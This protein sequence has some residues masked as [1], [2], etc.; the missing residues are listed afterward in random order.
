MSVDEQLRSVGILQKPRHWKEKYLKNLDKLSKPV[1]E[2]K[3]T[4]NVPVYMRD[5]CLTYVDIYSP[6]TD[7]GERFPGLVAFSAYGK[8][9]Q[10]LDREPLGLRA[11]TF[12]HTIEAGDIEYY[13]RRGYVAAI[14][15]PRGVGNSE[16]VWDGLYGR[17]EAE[18]CYDVI[19]W[20][21]RQEYCTGD[22]GM[23]GISYFSILQPLVAALQPPHLRAIMPVEVVDS[24]YHH[25]YP[26]GAFFDRSSIYND[27]CPVRGYSAS[28][29]MYTEEE[30]KLRIKER[31]ENPDTAQSALLR[32]VLTTW[33]PRHQSYFFDVVLH[34]HDDDFWDERSIRNRVRDI[35]VPMYLISEYYE[36]GR[37]TQGPFFVYN[38]CDQSVPRKVFAPEAHNSIRLPHRSMSEEYLRWYDHWLKGVDTGIMD[39]PPIK[40]YITELDRYRYEYEWPIARTS[41]IKLYLNSGGVLSE[42]GPSPKGAPPETFTHLPPLQNP[43]N[44]SE[45]PG[46]S[47]ET[48]ALE[49]DTEVTGNIALY[50]SAALSAPDGVFGINLIDVDENG[51]ETTVCSGYLRAS[52]RETKNEL[53]RPWQPTHDHTKEVPVTPGEIRSYAIEILP[54]S[55][56]FFAG[57]RI[58]ITVK[59]S[60]PNNYT[61]LT[62]LPAASE[63]KYDLSVDSEHPSYLLL[64]IIETSPEENWID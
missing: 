27:F 15:D 23:V 41:W 53:T 54:T 18:D 44:C 43:T 13:V 59:N 55:R 3:K 28:E 42:R 61:S 17:R 26:G 7:E 57:H 36:Y 32:R 34:N 4:E 30:L 12:D 63:I 14:P 35:K 25:N 6:D 51:G 8:S 9:L 47:F 46:L 40:L 19:E 37:F 38:N 31:L 64:P 58:K 48:A 56:M 5:G 11:V 24:L 50:L 52:H 29:R 49:K 1:Y 33:P 16:G 2:M 22:I 20:L 10:M 62:I 60:S 45:I 39:E 21:A